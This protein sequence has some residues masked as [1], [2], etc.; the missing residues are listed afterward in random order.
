MPRHDCS[1]CG[2]RIPKRYRKAHYVSHIPEMRRH[3]VK[4]VEDMELLL[5]KLAKEYQ[6]AG[7]PITEFTIRSAALER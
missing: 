4:A 1:V 6:N 3:Y 7:V 5:G 2:K